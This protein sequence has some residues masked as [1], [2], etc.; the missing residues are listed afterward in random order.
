[1]Q[2]QGKSLPLQAVQDKENLSH[3]GDKTSNQSRRLLPTR[4]CHQQ[5]VLAP[6]KPG[7]SGLHEGVFVNTRSGQA[8]NERQCTDGDVEMAPEDEAPQGG[9]PLLHKERRVKAA[10][11]LAPRKRCS[12]A[13]NWGGPDPQADTTAHAGGASCSHGGSAGE[14]AARP[15]TRVRRALRMQEGAHSRMTHQ[16]PGMTKPAGM[17]T[18]PPPE[19]MPL[20]HHHRSNNIQNQNQNPRSQVLGL[21]HAAMQEAPAYECPMTRAARRRADS[22][23]VTYVTRRQRLSLE[24]AA[25]CLA[26]LD[27][28]DKGI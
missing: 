13:M 1:M 6:L 19:P 18:Q 27:L 12:A 21:N 26:A 9:T 17:T 2:R 11:P 10:Q 22:P 20:N 16:P 7:G 28:R 23:P 15:R 3:H 14:V 4:A 24:G 5:Q 25:R 8:L